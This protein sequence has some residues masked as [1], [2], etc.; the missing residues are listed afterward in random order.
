MYIKDFNDFVAEGITMKIYI[1]NE[2]EGRVV[3]KS[4]PFTSYEKAK[5]YARN[6]FE[7]LGGDTSRADTFTE[8]G[9]DRLHAFVVRHNTDITVSPSEVV[10]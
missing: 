6:R 10:E 2:I 7:E 8:P 9:V 1:Y 5:E 3:R 4:I